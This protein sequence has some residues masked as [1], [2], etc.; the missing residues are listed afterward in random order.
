MNPCLDPHLY[1]KY[2]SSLGIISSLKQ[3]LN[4]LSKKILFSF[5]DLHNLLCIIS[6]DT[7]LKEYTNSMKIKFDQEGALRVMKRGLEK[8]SSY[9]LLVESHITIK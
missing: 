3:A 6:W 9:S 2:M 4:D 5:P 7:P 1:T 8:V